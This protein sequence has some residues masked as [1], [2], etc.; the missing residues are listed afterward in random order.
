MSSLPPGG[1]RHPSLLEFFCYSFN[2]LGLLTAPTFSF[3][4]HSR[5][6][7]DANPW[8]RVPT[9]F[10]RSK[11]LSLAF[12]VLWFAAGCVLD[13]ELSTALRAEFASAGLV[14]RVVYFTFA[15]LAVRSRYYIAWLMADI[16]SANMNLRDCAS[17]Y[18]DYV[19]NMDVWVFETTLSPRERIR[20]WNMSIAKWLRM[21]F[22]EPLVEHMGVAKETASL[23]TFLVSACW[24][25]FYVVY[26]LCFALFY[27]CTQTERHVFRRGW[28]GRFPGVYYHLLM[29]MTGIMF[30]FHVWET[31]LRFLSINWPF[32][33]FFLAV[34]AAV[35]CLPRRAVAGQKVAPPQ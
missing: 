26:Y 8:S 21:C 9:A 35:Q 32:Y 10:Y 6:V 22:Y 16:V 7:N 12:G 23:Y 1:F 31:E 4:E 13:P 17:G 30:R 14:F 34:L 27:V 33:A 24:H 3:E 25:G 20:H 29:D 11:L 18:R 5:L 15:G 2:F 28:A 19:M